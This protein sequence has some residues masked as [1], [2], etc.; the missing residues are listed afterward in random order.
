MEQ[1][2]KIEQ[3]R[4]KLIG[5]SRSLNINRVPTPTYNEFV[6]WCDENFAKDWGMGLK[7]LWDFYK[8]MMPMGQEAIQSHLE[9]LDTRINIIEGMCADIKN[10]VKK[11]IRMLSGRKVNRT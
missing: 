7:H 11:P 1:N 6:D 8:G 2:E 10:N 5:K 4:E 3:L 9:A